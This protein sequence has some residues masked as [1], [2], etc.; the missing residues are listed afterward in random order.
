M[1]SILIL[2]VGDLFQLLGLA[3]AS[4]HGLPWAKVGGKLAD[5]VYCLQTW[6]HGSMSVGV[7]SLVH[8]LRGPGG[9]EGPTA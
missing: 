8:M 9:M 2:K 5:G 1:S 4:S 7:H 3:L 6:V